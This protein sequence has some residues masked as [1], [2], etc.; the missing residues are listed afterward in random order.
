MKMDKVA[1]VT[2][3]AQGIGKCIAKTFLEKNV[4]VVIL[5]SDK[6]AGKETEKEYAPFGNIKFIATDI[7]DEASVKAAIKFTVTQYGKISYL[8]NNAGIM[9]RKPIEKLSVKEWNQVIGINLTGAFLCA[10]HAAPFL[11]KERGAI[12]NLASTRAFM[13]EPNTESYSA[14]KGGIMALTHALAISLGPKVRVNAI[15]PGWIEVA[16]W[17]KKSKRH[18]PKHSETDL[19][20]HPVGRVGVPQDI[21]AM[22]WFL[23][24]NESGFMTG[25]NV[26][27]DG[28]M[29][30]KM[31]YAE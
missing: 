29:T 21:A 7:A 2:G 20:Q 12:V 6:E 25:S 8:I 13:S 30:H 10:K 11:K 5:D 28:G 19:S 16:D 23:V 24:S 15:S 1:I 27:I 17:K 31:I 14:S 9:I 4:A 3:G 22:V 26:M 18:T